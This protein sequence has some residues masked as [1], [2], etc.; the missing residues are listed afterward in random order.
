[1]KKEELIEGLKIIS[2]P[3]N[4]TEEL[5]MRPV[6]TKKELAEWEAA[7]KLFDEKKAVIVE[8]EASW[9]TLLQIYG[10][11]VTGKPQQPV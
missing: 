5:H 10:T 11:K 2:V 8:A 9:S 6:R 4:Q 7:F 1:M 3:T